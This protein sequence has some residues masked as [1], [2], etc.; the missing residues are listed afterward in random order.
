MTGARHGGGRDGADGHSPLSSSS[1]DQ[2]V[3]QRAVRWLTRSAGPR[4]GWC[5]DALRTLFRRPSACCSA[6]FRPTSCRFACVWRVGCF[7]SIT[8]QAGLPVAGVA[9]LVSV[10]RLLWRLTAVVSAAGQKNSARV[11]TKH[12]DGV[13]HLYWSARP[14]RRWDSSAALNSAAV[15][16]EA[17]GGAAGG[18]GLSVS[19]DRPLG[20]RASAAVCPVI[21]RQGGTGHWPLDKHMVPSYGGVLRLLC[22]VLSMAAA[23][24][25]RWCWLLGDERCRD[26]S[27]ARLV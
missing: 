5:G 10:P 6:Q 16:R 27:S 9:R 7:V 15:L 12:G 23:A 24:L 22:S 8:R 17:S 4:P 3:G 21:A 1:G 26:G 2:S 13:H 19:A 20:R 18:G 11:L 25:L 14:L